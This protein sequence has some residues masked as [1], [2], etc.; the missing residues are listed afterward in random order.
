MTALSLIWP[1]CLLFGLLVATG[2]LLERQRVGEPITLGMLAAWSAFALF[3]P[4]LLVAV[5]VVG[6]GLVVWEV[7]SSVAPRGEA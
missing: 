7:F 4:L 5:I 3:W 2:D 1:L 6:C